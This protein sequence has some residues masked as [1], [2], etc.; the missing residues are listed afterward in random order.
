[1]SNDPSQRVQ[2]FDDKRGKIG[3]V[4]PRPFHDLC[5]FHE[6]YS[7]QDDAEIDRAIQR[8]ERAFELFIRDG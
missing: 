7:Y 3:T 5:S 2:A 6:R 8:V 4:L 1:M